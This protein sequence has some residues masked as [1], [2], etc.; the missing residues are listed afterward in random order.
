MAVITLADVRSGEV[1]YGREVDVRATSSTTQG[2]SRTGNVMKR[3]A[4]K[5]FWNA[6]LVCEARGDGPEWLSAQ[7][8]DGALMTPLN[9]LFGPAA[10]KVSGNGFNRTTQSL[11][12][13][14][15]AIVLNNYNITGVGV[16]TRTVSSE[17]ED[18][19]S[20]SANG[21]TVTHGT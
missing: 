9:I 8:E 20:I 17:T 14:G 7:A 2:L 21:V 5:H 10:L 15:G 13:D 11:D 18:F 1:T 4:M 3:T 6:T 12:V 16:M 19:V